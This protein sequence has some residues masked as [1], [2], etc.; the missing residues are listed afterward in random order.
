M[1]RGSSPGAGS[2]GGGSRGTSAIKDFPEAFAPGK[3]FLAVGGVNHDARTVSRTTQ[4]EWDKYSASMN[5]NVSA[6]DEA[7][8][9]REYSSTP[10]ANGDYVS[11][12]VRTRNAFAINEALYDPKNAGKTDAQ[13]FSRASD[14]KTV[15]ALDKAI[16][17]HSTPADGAYTRFTT[18][19]AIQAAFGLTNEQMDLI[20]Q[21]P[22]MTPKQ[23]AQLNK[24]LRGSTSFSNAYSS[25]S[26]NRTL[27]AFSNP[28]AKQS[29][30]FF[31]E[32]KMNAP[33]GTKAYAPRKNAQ[34]SEVIFG[35]KMQTSLAGISV[36]SDGHIVF[37]ESFDGYK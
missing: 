21:A 24:S 8:I 28:Y 13:I 19:N 23:L 34:E 11:G 9:M 1:G 12:Y 26:A 17:N 2:G 27:N 6:A 29:K 15:K 32:R 10:N 22:N 4:A 25:F 31:Y 16:N 36:S 5:A 30:G 18:R 14:R 33:K 35:R 37:H 20:A 7:A 3:D